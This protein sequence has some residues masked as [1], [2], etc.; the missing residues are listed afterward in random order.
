MTERKYGKIITVGSLFSDKPNPNL[1][2]YATA[3]AALEG[4]TRAMAFELAPKGIRVNMV[5]PSMIATDLTAD[6]PEKMKL[7]SAMQT[8]LRRLALPEDV[9]GA[10]SFLASEKSDYLS[11]EVIRINGGQIMK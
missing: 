9:A 6:I 8:P 1:V 7:L 10:V 4:F 2:H 3:K 11:G 5:S